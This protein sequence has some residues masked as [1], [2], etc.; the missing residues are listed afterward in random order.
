MEESK[1]NIDESWKSATDTEKENLKKDGK[2]VP[3]DADFKFF[4]TTLALQA[5]ISLGIMLN[6]STNQKQEDLPQA[7]FIIDTIGVL[8]DKT[9]GNLSEEEN[10]LLDNVLY[11][12]RTQYIA[13]TKDSNKPI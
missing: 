7:K 11:E 12:L 4:I 10:T 1:K 2:F 9:K 5:S 6:P 3:P 13:K 8:K